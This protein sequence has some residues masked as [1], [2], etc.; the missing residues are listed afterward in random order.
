MNR[1]RQAYLSCLFLQGCKLF[2]GSLDICLRER[3]VSCNSIA[4]ELWRIT[5]A[6]DSASGSCLS[7]SLEKS[8]SGLRIW[9]SD[10]VAVAEAVDEF[11][12]W[13]SSLAQIEEIPRY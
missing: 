8:L 1:G 7:T 6:K 5:K 12:D 13:A 4:I 3:L 11:R 9:P 2:N 10:M